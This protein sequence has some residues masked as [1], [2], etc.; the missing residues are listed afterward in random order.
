MYCILLLFVGSRLERACVNGTFFVDLDECIPY[1][2]SD[3]PLFL[4][5][6]ESVNNVCR[7]NGSIS[8][9]EQLE[10]LRYCDT[11]DGQLMID[12]PSPDVDFTVLFDLEIVT[13]LIKHGI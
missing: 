7:R 1:S 12:V 3:L 10:G 9:V 4:E 11:Y 6:Y 2:I 8:T 5:S 13:G